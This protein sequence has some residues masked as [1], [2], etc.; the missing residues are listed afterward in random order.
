S[1]EC[2]LWRRSDETRCNFVRSQTGFR[3]AIRRR[4]SKSRAWRRTGHASVPAARVE[5]SRRCVMW[6]CEWI[7][8]ILYGHANADTAYSCRISYIREKPPITLVCA[9][10]G[11]FVGGNPNGELDLERVNDRPRDFVLEC[12]GAVQLAVISFCPNAK[13]G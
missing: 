3:W 12:K 1:V 2:C 7:R 10:A 8:W 5:I 13:T 11:L 9:I 6:N 4:T